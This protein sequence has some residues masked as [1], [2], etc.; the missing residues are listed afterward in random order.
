[1]FL[2]SSICTCI[3]SR[4]VKINQLKKCWLAS[5]SA[6]GK[7]GLNF[8]VFLGSAR[9]SKP[10][11]PARVGERVA[12]FCVNQLEQRQKVNSV[13]LVDPIAFDSFSQPVFQPLFSYRQGKTPDD[14]KI[15]SEKIKQADGYI[16]VTPEYNHSL[17]PAL[18]HMLNHFPSSMFAFKPSAIVSYS[19]GQWGGTRAA[20]SLRP[21]LSELGCLPVSAMI[22]FPRAA[23]IVTEDGHMVSQE[24]EGSWQNYAARTFGQLEWWAD[25]TKNHKELVDPFKNSPAFQSSPSQRNAP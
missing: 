6:S 11:S 2:R 4:Q 7:A 16:M 13:F 18:A 14:L 24:D 12:K 25:A 9:N 8:V 19:A 17:S 20:A 21:F 10:P 1:M 23:D 5:A 22:H 15:L 3:R